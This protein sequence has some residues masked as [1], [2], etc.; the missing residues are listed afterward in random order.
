MQ[1]QWFGVHLIFGAY[2]IAFLS[3]PSALAQVG[4]TQILREGANLNASEINPNRELILPKSDV[5]AFGGAVIGLENGAALEPIAIP[6][7]VGYGLVPR[8]EVGAEIAVFLNRPEELSFFA[9][10]L[11]RIYGRFAV[12]EEILAIEGSIFIPVGKLG[13]RL[14]YRLEAPVRHELTKHLFVYGALT[15]Q[16]MFGGD[17]TSYVHFAQAGGAVIVRFIENLWAALEV[18]FTLRNFNFD[19]ALVPFGV[20]LG[21]EVFPGLAILPGLRFPD[22]GHSEARSLTILVVYT[23]DVGLG[24]AG[25]EST[26]DIPLGPAPVTPAEGASRSQPL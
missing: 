7:G 1:G 3:E 13:D 25:G 4:E 17:A 9:V 18:G 21:Y 19:H 22:I 20:S 16:A 15:Y 11:P 12:V 6:V 26:P 24:H 10:G 14:A 23:F 2:A 5:E 8:L